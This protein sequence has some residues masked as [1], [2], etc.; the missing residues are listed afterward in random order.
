MTPEE[1]VGDEAAKAWLNRLGGTIVA[2]SSPTCRSSD[3]GRVIDFFIIDKRVA[4]AV[5]NVFVAVDLASSPHSA[6]VVRLRRSATS[7]LMRMLRRPPRFPA[8][9]PMGCAREPTQP[10]AAMVAALDCL[11]KA[12][13]TSAVEAQGTLGAESVEEKPSGASL[14]AKRLDSISAGFEH[15]VSLAE[16]ELC[17]ICDNVGLM[18]RRT[19]STLAE[20]KSWPWYGAIR[21]RQLRVRM[22]ELTWPHKHCSGSA[23]G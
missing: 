3:G 19:V 15:L 9:K 13:L 1:L 16:C 7:A 21:R 23:S 8:L 6:V 2:P 18:V 10:N 4:H 20:A 17:G 22:A 5:A 12:E 14:A 11:G